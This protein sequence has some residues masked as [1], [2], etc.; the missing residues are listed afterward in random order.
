MSMVGKVYNR[1]LLNQLQPFTDPLLDHTQKC[2]RRGRVTTG[3][4]LAL[5]RIIEEYDRHGKHC[6]LT[7]IDFKKA[8][9]SINRSRM[10]KILEGH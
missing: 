10:K 1:I 7:F 5:R 2:F 6:I 3:H 8:F 9:D 4:I